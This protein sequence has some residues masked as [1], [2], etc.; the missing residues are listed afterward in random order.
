MN[1]EFFLNIIFLLSINLLIKPF[2]IFGI[3]RTVQNMVGPEEYG[4]YFSLFNFTFIFYMLNDFGIQSFNNRNIAQHNQLLD[5]YFPNILIL[6]LMLGF[7]YIFFVFAFGYLFGYD[8]N[9]YHL[10][11][12]IA[13]NQIL[14][15]FIFYLRSN[16]SALG[17]YRTDSLISALDKLLMIVIC[18]TLLWGNLTT[19][20]FQIE[21][22]VYAQ[23]CS[24]IL[25]AIVAFSIVFKQLKGFR[26]K[27]DKAFLFI[28]LRDSYPYAFAI[29]LMTIYSR[30]DAVMIERMLP[31]GLVETGIYASAYR[32]LDASNM[33]GF[34]FAG[35]LLPMFS[36]MIKERQSVRPLLKFSFQLIWS[37][38][39]SI[40]VACYFFQEEIM[41]LLY[42]N[43]TAYW[44]EILASLMISFIAVSAIYIFGSLLTAKGLMMKMNML[45]VF[46][47][48]LNVVLNY[49]LIQNY[50]A[51]GAAW[52]TCFTQFFV[53]FGYL[54]LVKKTFQLIFSWK[55]ILRVFS[56]IAM[57][58]IF[59]YL[60][61][62]NLT[63]DWRIKFSIVIGLSFLIAFALKMLD[64]KSFRQ[65]I[66][67]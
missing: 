6:K 1:R 34:L 11:F 16:I 23:M 13:I 51:L 64:F 17:K 59:N 7:V 24:L 62:Q 43:A 56:F 38:A 19:S 57:V 21:W 65:L 20:P 4:L 25:T 54:I 47:I 2:Y 8:Q 3:D 50:K 48:I 12:L 46:S 53:L 15:A 42:D 33:L 32:L 41:F 49:W 14:I 26:F 10:L 52:A 9:Y 30:I 58:I 61:Y 39:I 63:L 27:F 37:I 28:I 22:F 5:K 60:V 31:D 36:K 29:F 40:A 18:S 55:V 35:L 66:K 45:F 44:G 67:T